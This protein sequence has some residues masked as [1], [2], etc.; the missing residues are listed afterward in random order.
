MLVNEIQVKKKRNA[1]LNQA[2]DGLKRHKKK[3]VKQ[4]VFRDKL[5]K[6]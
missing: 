3:C 6:L 1:S 5:N 2:Y 4:S